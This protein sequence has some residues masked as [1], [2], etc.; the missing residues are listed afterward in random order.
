MPSKK[1]KNPAPVEPVVEEVVEQTENTEE[2][3]LDIKF[4]DVLG[5]LS[6]FKAVIKDCY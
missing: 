3:T 6:S 4:T 2:D 5:K 1:A